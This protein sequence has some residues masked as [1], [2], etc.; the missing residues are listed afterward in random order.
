MTG[1]RAGLSADG[2]LRRAGSWTRPF[3]LGSIGSTA[4]AGSPTGQELCFLSTRAL[5]RGYV[6]ERRQQDRLRETWLGHMGILGGLR[7]RRH[8]RAMSSIV[9]PRKGH[10][11]PAGL[12][13]FDRDPSDLDGSAGDSHERRAATRHRSDRHVADRSTS[14][15]LTSERL[16]EMLSGGD[17]ANADPGTSSRSP[18][19]DPDPASEVDPSRASDPHPGDSPGYLA[20]PEPVASPLD[21]VPVEGERKQDQGLEQEPKREPDPELERGPEGQ[22]E[23]GG[24]PERELV[25][26]PEREPESEP[27]M[28][29]VPGIEP[30][31][32]TASQTA[33][34]SEPEG[35]AEPEAASEPER[36]DTAPAVAGAGRHRRP[37]GPS[38]TGPLGLTRRRIPLL[39][40]LTL[41]LVLA[42]TLLG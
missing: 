10:D 41:V 16:A 42:L 27:E 20:A 39:V 9:V 38:K 19:Q 3:G 28:E 14:D 31:P 13:T 29:Q 18:D 11:A 8:R 22:A 1:A 33:T 21:S 7:D 17:L 40:A 35:A 37:P 34:A 36:L 12:R 5:A 30:R 24:E 6:L 32:R 2:R 26:E 4:R 25:P 15:R 23:L